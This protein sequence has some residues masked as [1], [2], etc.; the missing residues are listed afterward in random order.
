MGR[1]IW[2]AYKFL[3]VS[4]VLSSVVLRDLGNILLC[5]FINQSINH[6]SQPRALFL[7][8]EL[9]KFAT[10]QG[11][12]KEMPSKSGHLFCVLG[13]REFSTAAERQN[14]RRNAHSFHRVGSAGISGIK[15]A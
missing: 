4:V 11:G 14:K 5:S 7:C 9:T 10:S 6:A 1:R 12:F 2:Q 8:V 15:L 13:E 3:D